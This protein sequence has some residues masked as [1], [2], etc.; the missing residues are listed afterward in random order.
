[1][2]GSDVYLNHLPVPCPGLDRNDVFKYRTANNQLCSVDS[3]TV[4]IRSGSDMLPGPSC[5]LGQF[6]PV[7]R[8]DVEQLKLQAQEGKKP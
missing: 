3:I 1:M 2:K 8:D 6:Q 5:T 4:L 7:S